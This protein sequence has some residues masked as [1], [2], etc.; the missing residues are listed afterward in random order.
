[1][2][3]LKL[4]RW[5]CV[6]LVGMTGAAACGGRGSLPSEP[7]EGDAGEPS[8]GGG[9]A[10]GGTKGNGGK[11]GGSKGGSA[12]VAG[13]AG[14]GGAPACKP[15]TSVCRDNGVAACSSSGT[16]GKTRPCAKG[17]TCVEQASKATCVVAPVCQPGTTQ[18]DASGTQVERCAVDGASL[19]TIADCSERGQRCVGGACQSLMCQPNQ[20]YCDKNTLR[21]CAPDGKSSSLLL[22]CGA[23]QYCDA[24]T[25][26]C[27]AGLCAPN[28]PAC[29]GTIATTCNANGSGYV[30]GGTN[31]SLLR[32]RQCVSGACLCAPSLADCDGV[33]RNG[34]EINVTKDPDN[35]GTC[36]VACSSNH[37]ASRSCSGS[38]DGTC[39]AGYEDCNG[40]KLSDGC[41]TSI[42]ADAKNCG[43][44]GVPCS[45]NHVS[46]HCSK[47]TCD[48]KCAAGF[49]DCNDSKL[50]DG[51]ETDLLNDPNNCG[52][53]GLFCS[54]N[55]V[56]MPSCTSGTCSGTCSQGFA[57]C[58]MDRL[59]DGCETDL[60]NDA[61]NCGACGVTCA[62][63]DSCA[64]GKCRTLLT[65]S[66]IAQN[67]STSL[68]AGWSQC[69]AE[70][71]GQS[72]TSI[73]D[74][75]KLCSGSLVMLACRTKGSSTLQLAAYA[76]RGDVFFDT[77]GGGSNTAHDAN[78]VG[79]YYNSRYSW[80]FAPQG[81]PITRSSC[82]I[83]DSTIKGGVDGDKRLCWHTQDDKIAG[84]WRCGRSD[85]LNADL[86]FER[87]MFTA[88]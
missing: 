54:T 69:Y 17:Q 7:L 5:L 11:G 83:E 76:P 24:A 48:G 40:D 1:M 3:W 19:T 41:E 28:Q 43:G 85:N 34:C 32:D 80:G 9:G 53:C 31:C 14:M 27:E 45:T 35:C 62:S 67:L 78:G 75:Q 2:S 88:N 49:Q 10:N 25:L 38:C 13:V 16:M 15:G 51:C 29:N 68:L 72:L 57:D 55:H 81:D 73:A 60:L 87:V 84:G 12:G 59:G 4:G 21:L 8:F 74:V 23:K 20:A 42:A 6:G 30:A 18:C 79:W 26:S 64:N 50:K 46:P 33:V 36:D 65:F 37:V 77:G 58:N 82:D 70:T 86:S 39:A 22:T 66:G 52:K 56:A 63:G 44:C 61:S 71:Y 47:G